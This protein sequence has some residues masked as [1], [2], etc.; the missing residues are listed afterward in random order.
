MSTRE[1]RNNDDHDTGFAGLLGIFV[2]AL[3][4]VFVWLYFGSLSCSCGA[5]VI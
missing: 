4:G 5:Q 1:I 3:M 2:I